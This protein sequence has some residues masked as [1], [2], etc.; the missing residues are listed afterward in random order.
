MPL[1]ICA[2][3][4]TRAAPN[5]IGFQ[6]MCGFA[7]ATSASARASATTA[8]TVAAGGTPLLGDRLDV[9]AARGTPREWAAGLG[10]QDVAAE[11]RQ[12][13]E[14]LLGVALL[15]EQ[16]GAEHERPTARRASSGSGSSQRTRSARSAIPFRAAFARSSST[17]SSAQSV[18]STS[19]PPSAA[20]SDGRPSPAPSSSTRRPRRS[21]A[22]TARRARRRSARA[23]PSTAGTRPRRTPPRRSARRRSAGAA[24]VTCLPASSSVSSIRARRRG[25]R[26][27]PSGSCE[28]RVALAPE[29]VP[30]LL[31]AVEAGVDERGAYVSSTSA[32]LAHSNARAIW[33][34]VARVQSGRKLQDRPPRCRA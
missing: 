19:A 17:A 27:T 6:T 33:L 34:P 32:A 28:L 8:A 2:V 23:R 31:L 1:R 16:V 21:S 4:A 22:A 9:P 25:R 24:S 7:G 12:Q 20:A 14:Q 11:P 5:G 26:A 3:S 30:R 15:V 13:L 29:G 18:A 10:E